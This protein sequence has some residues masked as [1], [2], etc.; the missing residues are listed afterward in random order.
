GLLFSMTLPQLVSDSSVMASLFAIF[1][2][3]SGHANS[4]LSGVSWS[5]AGEMNVPIARPHCLHE[6][7]LFAARPHAFAQE[8]RI[9]R[10]E[11]KILK[12]NFL[13]PRPKKSLEGFEKVAILSFTNHQFTILSF[14][15]TRHATVRVTKEET[16]EMYAR[17][18]YATK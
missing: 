9:E 17:S 11:R 15:N 4:S 7:R 1:S 16:V 12:K 3:H 6:R 5:A 8:V 10:R 14:T 2:M 18:W 13:R